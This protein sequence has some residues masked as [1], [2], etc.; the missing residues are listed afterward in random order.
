MYG[1]TGV[2]AGVPGFVGSFGSFGYGFG[3]KSVFAGGVTPSGITGTYEPSLRQIIV[4]SLSLSVA[5]TFVRSVDLAAEATYPG[6]SGVVIAS[7]VLSSSLAFHV[8]KLEIAPVTGSRSAVRV[9]VNVC[10]LSG[11]PASDPSA[12]LQ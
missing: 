8:P 12:S 3:V 4:S 10:T 11:I 1:T 2:S 6:L 7:I 5:C 9:N